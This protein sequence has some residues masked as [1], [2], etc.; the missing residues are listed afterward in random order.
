[1]AAALRGGRMATSTPWS[2]MYRDDLARRLDAVID[3]TGWEAVA[4]VIYEHR[5]NALARYAPARELQ[6]E[7]AASP[8][9]TGRAPV[10]RPR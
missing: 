7:I 2:E 5:V 10:S 1:M 3:Q 9:R 8:R 6:Q 4:L